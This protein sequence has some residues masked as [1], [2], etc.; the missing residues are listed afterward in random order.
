MAGSMPTGVPQWILDIYS[1]QW[2]CALR[3]YH[4]MDQSAK[5]LCPSDE[6]CVRY[7]KENFQPLTWTM[8][9]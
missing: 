4:L 3:H 7:I 2:Q 9:G 5:S 8:A 6:Y 1:R